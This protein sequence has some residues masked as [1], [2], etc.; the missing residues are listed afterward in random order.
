[1]LASETAL[2]NLAD[3]AC[4]ASR[5]LPWA[6]P[7][8]CLVQAVLHRHMPDV[9]DDPPPLAHHS[10]RLIDAWSGGQHLIVKEFL[11]PDEFDGAPAREYRALQLL[12]PLDI[13][14][15]PV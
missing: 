13:A 9:Q 5:N 8:S 14:P 1:L 11:K 3:D 4:G 12:A 6:I 2:N 10:N 15:Q 7:D